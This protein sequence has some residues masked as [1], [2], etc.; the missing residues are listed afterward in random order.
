M[1]PKLI[2]AFDRLSEPVF[3][4]KADLIYTSI[5]ANVNFPL[6]WPAPVP[7]LPD[8][9]AAKTNYHGLFEAAQSGD[10]G[11][12]AARIIARDA[13][14]TLL[15][16]LAPYLELVAAGNVA[17]LQTTGY[18]LRHDIVQ[19]NTDDPLPGPTSFSFMRGDVSGTLVASADSLPGAGSYILQTCTGDPAVE[20]NWKPKGTLLHCS[21]II[22]DGYIPGTVYYARLQGIGTNG[23]GVWSVS[24][25]VMA[26]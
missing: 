7:Q 19:S 25:G 26:V 4:T 8:I 24:E 17:K 15:K 6:P 2:I 22:T 14:T 16:N 23:P 20:A 10:A 21:K 9:L 11:K 3:D 18:D 1:Q 5:A 12:I 13:L